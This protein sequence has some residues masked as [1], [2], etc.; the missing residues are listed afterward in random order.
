MHCTATMKS[1]CKLVSHHHALEKEDP[2]VRVIMVMLG[3]EG[4][5]AS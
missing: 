5:A 3:E 1:L 4:N 2:T